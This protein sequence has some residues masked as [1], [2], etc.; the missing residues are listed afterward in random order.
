[1][2]LSFDPHS[3]AFAEDPYSFYAELRRKP[4]LTYYP[5]ENVWLASRY[6]D[7]ASIAQ[8]PDMLR[9]LNP[10][11]DEAERV[12]R[13]R[14]AN[15][16]DMPYHSRIVQTNLLE[17]DGAPHRRL[18]NMVFG[19]FQTRMI[20]NHASSINHVVSEVLSNIAQNEPFDFISEIAQPLPGRII[21]DL[22]GVPASD[23]ALIHDW[24]H[25]IVSYFD[26]D[27]TSEKKAAAEAA[28]KAFFYYLQD[29]K[30][31]REKT[32][33][34]DLLSH[35]IKLAAGDALSDDE[36]ISTCMLILMAGHGSSTD[37]MGSGLHLLFKHPGATHQLRSASDL[38]PAAIEEMFRYE[39]PLPYFVRYAAKDVSV[40]E[41]SYPAGTAFGLIY[42]SANRD[43][44]VFDNADQFLINRVH[45]R[46][47]SFGSGAHLCLGNNLAKLVMRNL[48]TRLLQTFP[49]LRLED[50]YVQYKPGL[51]IRGPKSLMINLGAN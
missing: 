8:N 16:H 44:R 27:R 2:S 7:V 45:N 50:E 1:M 10:F 17:L 42:A 21:G 9:S 35:I 3:L 22:I 49:D 14:A 29:I 12:K 33:Q 39:S 20:E 4:S 23:N 6:S 36:I 28:A 46:H 11:I 25:A 48:F 19:M 31:L 26:V 38:M 13:Q 43:E 15:F 5:A 41:T 47:L 30:Q 32:P 51:T 24:S 40:G 37:V 18:R 34:N